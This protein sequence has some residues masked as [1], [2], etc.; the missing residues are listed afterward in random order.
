MQG[1]VTF[2]EEPLP[3]ES[4]GD[5]PTGDAGDGTPEADGVQDSSGEGAPEADGVQDSSGEGAPEADGV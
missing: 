4:G 3:Q 1:T 2:Q 5:E